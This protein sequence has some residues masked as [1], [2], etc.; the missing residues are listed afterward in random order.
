MSSIE[1]A[2]DLP[3]I[4]PYATYPFGKRH[5]RRV[6]RVAR[7]LAGIMA[8]TC[9]VAAV[10]AQSPAQKSSA[11]GT[12]SRTIAA[13]RAPSSPVID[14]DLSDAAWAQASRATGFTDTMGRRPADDQTEALICYDDE[15]I[16]VAFRCFDSAPSAIVAR[17]TVRDSQLSSD[18]GGSG[19]DVVDFMIDPFLS[20]KW[21]DV[22]RFRVNPIGTRSARIGGGR[23]AKAEW[24][25]DW[26]A[27]AKRTAEGWTAE[28]RIPWPL[29]SYPQSREPVTMGVNFLRVQYRTHIASQWSDLG[30][31]DYLERQG[32]WTDVRPP[33]RFKPSLSV[34]QYGIAGGGDG[35]TTLRTGLD[36]RGA[37]TPELTAVASIN[38]DFATVEGAVES[39]T[40]TRGERF[41]EERRPFFLEG[42][43]YVTMNTLSA[44]GMP[45]HSMRIPAFDLGAKLYGKIG[46]S[47]TVGALAAVSFGER[48][49]FVG[50]V[51]H[52]LSPVSNVSA[53][54]QARTI[55][56]ADN[57]AA[58]VVGEQRSGNWMLN[59]QGGFSGGPNSGGRMVQAAALYLAR[60]SVLGLVGFSLDDRYLLPHGFIPFTG[61]KGGVAILQH[62]AEWRK[63][64]W[65]NFSLEGEGGYQVHSDGRPFQRGF[66]LRGNLVSRSDYALNLNVSRWKFENEWDST[67][68]L[69]FGVRVSDRF[70]R[71]GCMISTGTLGGNRQTLIGP[72]V[73]VRIL[74]K[75][76]IGFSGAYQRLG[77]TSQ[78]YVTTMSYEFSPTRSVGGRIVVTN[79]QT[80]GYL[81]YRNSG[82]KGL[83]TYMILGDPNATTFRSQA[84]LK[85][86][87]PW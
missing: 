15:A 63:G 10:R 7:R 54:V 85:L 62:W 81:S 69:G 38:P 59:L 49:D 60:T 78:Q 43:R 34:L 4:L 12:H 30:P 58:L 84:L 73:N 27:A 39:I 74:R 31:L 18:G 45:F 65:R 8:A 76:D 9:T 70:N 72:S 41:V 16:Y 68:S 52:D 64:A 86:V 37:L 26:A 2:R 14:G 6:A 33:V 53:M 50:R 44:I 32:R 71:A 1:T 17:E 28:M 79:G 22:S 3:Q 25:G 57:T 13:V 19:E 20:H 42:N 48:S 80:N 36:A 75:L 56:G 55:D 77:S 29:L 46:K 66:G 5:L 47:D 21:D 35:S 40:F 87:Q 24:S 67:V 61:I 51:R 83:E 11:D 23:G 82:G